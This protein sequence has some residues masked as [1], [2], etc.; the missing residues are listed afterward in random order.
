LSKSENLIK[1]YLFEKKIT[2]VIF[3][4]KNF[5]NAISRVISQAKSANVF[6]NIFILNENLLDKRVSYSV[7]HRPLLDEL[8]NRYG[9]ILWRTYVIQEAM[10]EHPDSDFFL[11]LD[12]GSEFNISPSTLTR[13]AEYFEICDSQDLLAMQSRDSEDVMTPCWVIEDISP[14]SKK[15]KHFNSGAFFIKNTEFSKRF[16][17][18]WQ[19]LCIKNEY[20]Y[21]RSLPDKACCEE[22]SGINLSGQRVF[23]CLLH[24]YNIV[25]IEDEADWYFESAKV[26]RYMEENKRMYPIFHARNF[27]KTSLL[28]SCLRYKNALI[29]NRLC[30]MS[31]TQD[32][33]DKLILLRLPCSNY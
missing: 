12:A 30:D 14:N 8:P 4:D 28:D 17:L 13:L 16:I 10:S 26:S 9:G 25:G 31:G 2:L 3:A 24:K 18:E 1:K 20:F 32:K 22:W 27:F 7:R 15:E 23:S 29:H 5:K 33:C 19:D 11:Y 21:I 6:S